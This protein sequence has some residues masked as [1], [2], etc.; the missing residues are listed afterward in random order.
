MTIS[1]AKRCAIGASAAL[2]LAAAGLIVWLSRP[3]PAGT[4]DPDAQAVTLEDRF[5]RELRTTRAPD[6]S[7]GGWLGLAEMD[8]DLIAAFVAAEDHRFYRHGGVDPRAVARAAWTNLRTGRIV[9]GG[10]TI[11]M[12]VARMLRPG[13]RSWTG[14][15]GQALWALRLEWHLGKQAILEQYLNRVPLGQGAVGVE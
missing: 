9:S 2:A 8:A 14:K 7:R 15:A 4:L 6:G 12:Q 11:T 5:G 10:S 1:A 13:S 3:L